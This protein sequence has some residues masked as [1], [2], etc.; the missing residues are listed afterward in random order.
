LAHI[1]RPIWSRSSRPRSNAQ[2]LSFLPLALAVPIGLSSKLVRI[3]RYP[4]GLHSVK[5]NVPDQGQGVKGQGQILKNYQFHL[6]GQYCTHRSHK[7]WT[8]GHI[9]SPC[10][11]GHINNGSLNKLKLQNIYNKYLVKCEIGI[12]T[13]YRFKQIMN[14]LSQI[15]V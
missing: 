5:H 9:T 3:F 2:N 15:L 13:D 8:G 4:R 11:C 12:Y 1:L 7:S 6:Y 10:T 14:K